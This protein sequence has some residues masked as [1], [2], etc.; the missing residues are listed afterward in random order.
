M[1]IQ[2]DRDIFNMEDQNNQEYGK[3]EFQRIQLVAIKE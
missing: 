3:R 2:R 1:V